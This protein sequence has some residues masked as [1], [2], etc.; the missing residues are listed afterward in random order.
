M[1][2]EL[3]DQQREAI[4]LFTSGKKLGCIAETLN[5]RRET[6]WRWRQLPEF[7]QAH[8]EM[9]QLRREELREQ[10][11]DL[12]RLSFTVITRELTREDSHFHRDRQLAASLNILKMLQ[13][14]QALENDPPPPML[15]N[16]VPMA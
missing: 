10:V 2:H 16:A 14:A 5:I 1:Q 3:T 15:D 8:Q 11:E 7:Q 12:V 13:P 6:L 4:E 9:K